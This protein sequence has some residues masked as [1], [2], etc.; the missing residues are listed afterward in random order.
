M[1][2][3]NVF[4]IKTFALGIML[5]RFMSDM[6]CWFANR[7]HQHLKIEFYKIKGR[8]LKL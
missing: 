3:R 2:V 1:L 6:L 4:L 7:E 5:F 8:V